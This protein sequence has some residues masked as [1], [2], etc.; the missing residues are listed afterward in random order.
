M[1]G[2][3]GVDDLGDDG[4]V[5]AEDAGEEGLAGPEAGD[6]ILAEFVLDGAVGEAR[7]GEI[8]GLAESAEGLRQGVNGELHRKSLLGARAAPGI[9]L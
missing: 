2:E 9:L 3:D 8:V 1:A 7:F 4:I 6:E 5:V